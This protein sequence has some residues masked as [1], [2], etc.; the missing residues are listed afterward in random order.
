MPLIP[1]VED[2]EQ[3]MLEYTQLVT[4]VQS[5]LLVGGFTNATKL[6]LIQRF[7]Y[8]PDDV[9]VNGTSTWLT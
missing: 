1:W 8:L 3:A 5:Q 2:D 4:D 6:K 7:G 9:I